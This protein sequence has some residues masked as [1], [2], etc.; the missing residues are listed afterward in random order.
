M[1][2]AIIA[3]KATLASE[4]AKEFITGGGGN[5]VSRA[6]SLISGDAQFFSVQPKLEDLRHHLDSDSLQE[7]RSAM[8]RIIAQMCKGN[9]MS[10]LFA[11]V[12]KN[13]HTSSIELR[14]LIYLYIT[15]YAEDRPNEAL[16]SISAFQKDLMDPSMHVRSLALRMLSTIRIPAIQPLVLL[17][18]TKSASD[19]EPLV[20]KTAAISLA[21]MHAISTNDEDS[22]TVYKLLGQ[23]LADKSAEVTSAAALSFIEICPDEMGLIHAVYRDLCR[24]LLD[25]D[26]WGQVVLLHVLLRYA[27]TQFMDPNISSKSCLTKQSRKEKEKDSLKKHMVDKKKSV[28][29]S[30]LS[31]SSSSS[32]ALSLMSSTESSSD[33]HSRG[34]GHGSHKS[35]DFILDADHRLLI[36]SVKPLFMSL[37]SAVVVA[38]TSLFYHCAPSVELD[39]CVRPLLRLLGGPEERHAIV[40]S[41]I[42]T[43]VLSR[44]E[45]FVPY[46]KEF[47]LL[48]HDVS[49]V[50]ELKLRIISKLATKDNFM[51]LFREFRVYVR[52]FHVDNVVD[53]VRGLGLI[54]GR[55]P[56]CAPQVMRL[57]VPLISHHNA[58][59]VSECI[60]VLRLLVIQGGDKARTSQ[61]VYRLL[62]QVVKGEITVESAKASI[63]WLVGENIQRHVA[64]AT[65]APEC[66]RVFAKR[67]SQEGL[68]VKKQVLMLGCKIWLFLDGSSSMADR[69]CKLFFYV[70]ELARFDEDYEVRDCGRLIQCAVNRQSDTF[71]ALKHVL[72][73]EKPLPQS[74]DPYVERTQYQL[75]TMSHLFGNS[76]FG[77]RKLPPWSE[78][79][80][81]PMLRGPQTA[82][83]DDDEDYDDDDSSSEFDS[84]ASSTLYSSYSE[85][86]SPVEGESSHDSLRSVSSAGFCSEKDEEQESGE[87]TQ[88]SA[89]TSKS[90]SSSSSPASSVAS[91][92]AVTATA[93]TKTTKTVKCDSPKRLVCHVDPAMTH[94]TGEDTMDVCTHGSVTSTETDALKQDDE[95]STVDV[96]QVTSPRDTAGGR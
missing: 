23:L 95:K 52:S 40:L 69:F 78:V 96:L 77:Y 1:S 16:L 89:S 51:E 22:E 7:K 21:Q 80:T 60:S 57:L 59:V 79:P 71:A 94:G 14:K 58:E 27:R 3:E 13:I 67:F 18:V 17:A 70:L 12:V 6:R 85:T 82:E 10:N 31:S 62:Q 88:R 24:S 36:D 19:S 30:S 25:C 91:E 93:T 20:R 90:S 38:A 65:A 56:K 84:D 9:D 72:L 92:A 61:L 32:S 39:V 50:R 45:P 2:R 68:D 28:T 37:N 11:D 76:L 46:I 15:H 66:F 8:K 29:T 47:Y 41:A 34:N 64:I 54:A 74:N 86:S 44:P 81:D 4:R 5:I 35:I 26:E 42:Y 33:A 73:S 55:L 49:D 48:P 87:N 83:Y 63:L 75:G 43:V 53:A